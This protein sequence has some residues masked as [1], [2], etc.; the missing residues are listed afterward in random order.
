[1]HDNYIQ[2][3]CGPNNQRERLCDNQQTYL[4]HVNESQKLECEINIEYMSEEKE[5]NTQYLKYK[6][7][8]IY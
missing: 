7:A 3:Q 8:L 5:E 2:Y 6:H 1:M 4:T